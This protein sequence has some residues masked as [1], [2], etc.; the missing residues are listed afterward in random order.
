MAPILFH[1]VLW[2]GLLVV[3]IV[4]YLYAM[5]TRRRATC[6]SC[7]ERVQMEHDT[8]TNCPSCGAPLR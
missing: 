8:V 2:G 4:A 3:A 5:S 6:R 7:G 1:V